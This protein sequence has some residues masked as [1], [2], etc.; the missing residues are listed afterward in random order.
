MQAISI[1]ISNHYSKSI[2]NKQIKSFN[3]AITMCGYAKNN[4]PHNKKL[5]KQHLHWDIIDPKNTGD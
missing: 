4:F 2:T 1:D 5:V 3:I